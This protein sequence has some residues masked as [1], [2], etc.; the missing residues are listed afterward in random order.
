MARK[1]LLAD[2]SVT[3]QNMGRKIL[4][5]AGYEVI[6]VN[7]GSAALKRVNESKPD[8]IILDVYM[9]GY[10]GLEVC[11]RLKEAPATTYIPVLL[12]VGKLEP[13]KPDEARRARA[14]A[15][16]IKPFEASELLTAVARLEDRMVPLADEAHQTPKAAGGNGSA[17]RAAGVSTDETHHPRS[18]Q[19]KKQAED[20]TIDPATTFQD[21]RK[22]ASQPMSHGVSTHGAPEV[23]VP[24]T[25]PEIP[26]DITP[27]E[28][29]ALTAVAAQLGNLG[30]G[31]SL[32]APSSTSQPKKRSQ[33]EEF[34]CDDAA[35]AAHF[36]QQHGAIDRH[37]EPFFAAAS[38]AAP[39]E[40]FDP[41]TP[42]ITPASGITANLNPYLRKTFERSLEEF[43]AATPKAPED[44]SGE[45]KPQSVD[46]EFAHR[47]FVEHTPFAPPVGAHE[48]AST[49]APPSEEELAQ[50]LRLLT[51]AAAQEDT[52][53]PQP[54]TAAHFFAEGATASPF[55]SSPVSLTP[56]SSNL[57]SSH[58]YSSHRSCALRWMAETVALTPEE[59]SLSLEAEMFGSHTS[60]PVGP[61][62]PIAAALEERAAEPAS[63]SITAAQSEAPTEA[64]AI[65]DQGS[66]SAPYYSTVPE[67]VPSSALFTAVPVNTAADQ[68]LPEGKQPES[69]LQENQPQENQP[70][71]SYQQPSQ[72][73][74][75]APLEPMETETAAAVSAVAEKSI[76]S[77]VEAWISQP[78]AA[79]ELTN[80]AD[81]TG[82]PKAMAAAAAAESA[83]PDPSAIASIVESVLADLRPRILEE[84]TRKLS[85]K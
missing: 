72:R 69:R 32:P 84:I 10:S 52:S 12:T 65:A 46:E 18:A 48:L 43:T 83:P 38:S 24:E 49:D 16:I 5:D 50:A 60:A 54:A 68:V 41:G 27:D 56:P 29:D 25:D 4:V 17:K 34:G 14:D 28:L 35:N 9:P 23:E 70:Q 15:H 63:A 3:A 8:L 55:F 57:A 26:R 36:T 33:A 39:V 77:A 37:D 81:P 61:P 13:F 11:E 64:E 22:T 30:A 40:N 42:G 78:G 85:E 79:A 7:N 47:N 66:P 2:D 67:P 58:Q 45:I 19:K 73:Q 31:E 51:P 75:F 53:P 1:I 6:T 20:E 21:F 62:E 44:G 76:P 82:S 59:A 80:Q 71:A 74:N